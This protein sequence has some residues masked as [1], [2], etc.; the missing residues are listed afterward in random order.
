M[1]WEELFTGLYERKPEKDTYKMYDLKENYRI[2]QSPLIA[3]AESPGR[4]V[5]GVC[6]GIR[7][8]NLP[9]PFR[10]I[11]SSVAPCPVSQYEIQ[12]QKNRYVVCADCK[13]ASK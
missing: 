3:A 1:P 4:T 13:V 10:Q 12:F 9:L 5:P 8:I 7:L 2:Q 6:D 11:G